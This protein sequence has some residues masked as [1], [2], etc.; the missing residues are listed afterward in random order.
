MQRVLGR[1][2]GIPTTRVTT[3][4]AGD[5]GKDVIFETD[6]PAYLSLGA[7]DTTI[8]D[9]EPDLDAGSSEESGKEGVDTDLSSSTSGDPMVGET[10]EDVDTAITPSA[11]AEEKAIPSGDII[12]NDEKKEED[13]HVETGG[14]QASA[15][16][17]P[18]A[19]PESVEKK[20]NMPSSNYISVSPEE[21]DRV[22]SA[23]N[24][25]YLP[26]NSVTRMDLAV[27]QGNVT[28]MAS[29]QQP[30]ATNAA[31]QLA[32]KIPQIRAKDFINTVSTH[33]D[34][35]SNAQGT[36]H[37]NLQQSGLSQGAA[38][39]KAEA[40][41]GD[42]G[43]GDDLIPSGKRG[44]F[45]LSDIEV[46]MGSMEERDKAKA[47]KT[48]CNMNMSYKKQIMSQQSELESL[49]PLQERLA[50]YEKAEAQRKEAEE[51]SLTQE[52]ET[53]LEAILSGQPLQTSGQGSRNEQQEQKETPSKLFIRRFIGDD[54]DP[55][56]QM[57]NHVTATVGNDERYGQRP[58]DQQ[59]TQ[60]GASS[61]GPVV[62]ELI[63]A[64]SLD[65]KRKVF[66]MMNKQRSEQPV[67]RKTT[68]VASSEAGWAQHQYNESK[69]R[70]GN[71]SYQGMQ[72]GNVSEGGVDYR[73]RQEV[74]DNVTTDSIRNASA[75]YDSLMAEA[76]R[77]NKAC[78]A[79]NP[80][81][82]G[83]GYPGSGISMQVISASESDKYM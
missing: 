20:E 69:R 26:S 48:L 28:Q 81:S 15:I 61:Y 38:A 13:N 10:T 82:S 77:L 76:D 55:A 1:I 25:I 11:V 31:P 68:E 66:E 7:M 39:G 59:T 65:R 74:L 41:E 71:D 24:N 2:R 57:E 51:M 17:Q 33:M 3:V 18:P 8:G 79:H 50:Q 52:L 32:K 44:R 27:P 34:G 56:A 46:A 29:V 9:Q 5:D 30:D 83:S 35:G 54:N 6:K 62:K 70:R 73:R 12:I 23:Q 47:V 78:A 4:V 53:N 14:N 16:I 58:K 43:E 72:G 49:R 19:V 40:M 42:S 60:P 45:I 21:T 37:T 36:Q 80:Y 64:L 63:G 67:Y 22:S 75:S